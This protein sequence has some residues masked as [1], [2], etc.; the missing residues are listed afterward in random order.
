MA[1]QRQ[2]NW[3]AIKNALR[4]HS[5]KTSRYKDKS[6]AIMQD[7]HPYW[8]ISAGADRGSLTTERVL[9]QIERWSEWNKSRRY[10]K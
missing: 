8:V 6:H 1:R 9:E 3:R 5:I 10:R 7:G 4:M 2:L